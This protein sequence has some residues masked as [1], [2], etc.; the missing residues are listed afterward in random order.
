MTCDARSGGSLCLNQLH[1]CDSA[2]EDGGEGRRGGGGLRYVVG[3]RAWVRYSVY[4]CVKVL[5]RAEHC[6]SSLFCFCIFL[7][8]RRGLYDF[9]PFSFMRRVSV[10]RV[11][12]RVTRFCFA[13]G[14]R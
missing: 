14:G 3:A 4:N 8:S 13:L 10:H 9:G 5:V 6:F 11:Y 1:S 2:A 12:G 7:Q